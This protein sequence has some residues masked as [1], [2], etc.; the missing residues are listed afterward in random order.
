MAFVVIV[1]FCCCKFRDNL[2]VIPLYI[3]YLFSSECIKYFL[4]DFCVLQFY[5]SASRHG[6]FFF[7][8]FNLGCSVLLNMK[9]YLFY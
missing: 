6:F 5:Y 2:N 4:F 1:N 3:I 7:Y 9:I 8:V